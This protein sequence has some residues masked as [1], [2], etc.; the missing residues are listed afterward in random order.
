MTINLLIGVYDCF[1]FI[2]ATQLRHACLSKFQPH[3]TSGDFTTPA[4][5]AARFGTRRL[6][7]A[8]HSQQGQVSLLR[9]HA[10]KDGKVAV[11]KEA[12]T[13]VFHA[14]ETQQKLEENV[15]KESTGKQIYSEVRPIASRKPCSQLSMHN[16]C[17]FGI[18][19]GHGGM[20]TRK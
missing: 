8:F 18:K 15:K 20:F 9:P 16:D 13:A 1:P 19:S 4:V 17:N 7:L 11:G 12:G 10:V 2:K 14:T 6:V 5:D 3:E